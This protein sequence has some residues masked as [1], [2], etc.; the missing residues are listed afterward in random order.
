MLNYVIAASNCILR[1]LCQTD[2]NGLVQD[3]SISSVLTMEIE[4]I[5]ITSMYSKQLGFAHFTIIHPYKTMPLIFSSN[6]RY[7]L[8]KYA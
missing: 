3:C 6:V 1:G 8:S 2:M 4:T 7:T 5:G